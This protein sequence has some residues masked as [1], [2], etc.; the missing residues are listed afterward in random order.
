M[1]VHN[2]VYPRITV[3]LKQ[4]HLDFLDNIIKGLSQDE[5]NPPSRSDLIRVIIDKHLGIEDWRTKALYEEI[6]SKSKSFTISRDKD[7]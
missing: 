5:T 4:S 6:I 3:Y 7:S 2:T 1:G